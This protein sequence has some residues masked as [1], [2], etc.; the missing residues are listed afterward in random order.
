LGI[1]VVRIYLDAAPTIYLVEDVAPYKAALD[2]LLANPSAKVVVS[3][4][5][6][7]ECRV[8]P[9]R[10]NDL[11]LLADFDQFFD[12]GAVEVVSLTR[13]VIDLAT[14]LRGRN[15]FKTPDSIHLAAAI[16]AGCSLFVTNDHRLDRCTEIAVQVLS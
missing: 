11:E 10:D 14:D 6:R 16:Q 5:T 8:R 13:V 9:I 4:L 7:M 1:A 15:G 3:D 2:S 12:D